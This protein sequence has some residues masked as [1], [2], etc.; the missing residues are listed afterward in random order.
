MARTYCFTSSLLLLAGC[1]SSDPPPVSKSEAPVCGAAATAE[2][3]HT[4]LRRLSRFEYGRTLEDL[5][6]VDAAL[7]AELPPD[8]KSL[9]FDDIA[10]AHSISALHVSKYLEI[11][12]QVA[13]SLVTDRERL[14]A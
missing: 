12:D 4:P 5:L 14:R 1:A 10:D 13:N 9:G 6:G 7:A 3:G 2:L 8:E 11:G